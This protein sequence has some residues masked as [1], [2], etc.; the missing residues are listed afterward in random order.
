MFNNATQEWDD[1]A[2]S[3]LATDFTVTQTDYTLS[4]TENFGS[5][6]YYASKGYLPEVYYLIK[7]VWQSTYSEFGT[8]DAEKWELED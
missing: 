1:F 7:V 5:P 4:L 8:K 6:S 3:D 2:I